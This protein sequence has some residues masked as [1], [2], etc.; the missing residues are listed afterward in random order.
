MRQLILSE[1]AGVVR[2]LVRYQHEPYPAPSP[3]AKTVEPCAAEPM[4]LPVGTLHR[5]LAGHVSFVPYPTAAVDIPAVDADALRR[6]PACRRVFLGQL[7]Y[8]VTEM[9]LQWLCFTFGGGAVLCDAERITKKQPQSAARL[10]TGCIHAFI[11]QRSLDALIAGMHKRLLVD[12][13]GVWVARS[14]DE[15]V[16]LQDYVAMLKGDA[17]MRYPLRPY[18]TVVVQAATSSFYS[19]NP[20]P[21]AAPLPMPY[22]AAAAEP[23]A[24]AGSRSSSE[25][26]QRSPFH[27]S[28]EELF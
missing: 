13:T 3:V 11:H 22:F 24:C 20:C 26:V 28:G 19:R 14:Y 6:D 15:A 25:G 18:D 12:D 21:V 2:K 10:P 23:S 1:S 17:S 4:E 7:P 16:V 9:Q 27:N 5:A 8:Y